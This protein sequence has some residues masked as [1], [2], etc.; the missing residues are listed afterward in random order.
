MSRVGRNLLL[1]LWNC[2]NFVLMVIPVA[3]CWYCYYADRIAAPFFDR[4]NWA[5]LA[6]YGF[7][8]LMFGDVYEIYEIGIQKRSML[9]YSQGLA[10]LMS[11]GVLFVVIW[12]L[13][14]TFPNP[15]PGLAALAAQILLSVC[16]CIV[17]GWMYFG[18]SKAKRTAAVYDAR[19]GMEELLHDY[20]MEHSFDVRRVLPVEEC[21][22]DPRC[23]LGYDAVFLS[24]VRSEDRNDLLKFCVANSIQ[25]YVIPRIGDVIMSGA[26]RVHMLHLPVLQV[27]RYEP[28]PEFLLLKR[29]FDIVAS[30]IVLVLLSPLMLV[31]SIAIKACDGGPVFYKQKRLTKDGR[32]F[33]VLNVFEE[34]F[35]SA[36]CNKPTNIAV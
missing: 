25:V 16:W 27:G 14:H 23:L 1:H 12:L 30:A 24:D 9:I 28:T 17:A 19:Q 4:G 7:L 31:T 22:Y 32:E 11:D 6:L 33:D 34:V 13:T 29:L 10:A 8:Y 18:T 21:I 15:L 5:V 35:Q 26:K 36:L 2:V 3:M 20:E